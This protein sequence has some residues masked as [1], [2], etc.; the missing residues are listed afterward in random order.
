MLYKISLPKLDKSLFSNQFKFVLFKSSPAILASHFKTIK[1]LNETEKFFNPDLVFTL[2]GPSY[3]RPKTKHVTGFADGWVYNPKSIAF[4]KLSF[5]GKIKRRLL[6][7]I[8]IYLLKKNATH[9]ILET[10][11]AKE[12]FSKN[13]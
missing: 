5:I 10:N 13:I 8:K 1:K 12:K 2:F 11:D 9:F 4:Q 3:W 6:S 7:K